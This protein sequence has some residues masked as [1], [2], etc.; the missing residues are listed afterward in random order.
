MMLH[1]HATESLPLR[2]QQLSV[3]PETTTI[4]HPPGITL[5]HTKVNFHGK[6]HIKVNFHRKDPS[7]SKVLLSQVIPK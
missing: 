7:I 6:E 1:I 2:Y 5:E 3:R 4:P